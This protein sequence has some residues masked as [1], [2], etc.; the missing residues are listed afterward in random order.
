MVSVCLYLV[1]TCGCHG[2]DLCGLTEFIDGLREL[3][4]AVNSVSTV[5]SLTFIASSFSENVFCV[6]VFR[7]V[8]CKFSEMFTF[9]VSLT[10]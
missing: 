1:Y 7:Q 4:E 2:W 8:N 5:L 3:A 9:Q 6:F 10:I